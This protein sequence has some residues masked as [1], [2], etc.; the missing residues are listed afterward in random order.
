MIDRSHEWLFFRGRP[1][2]G[3][4]GWGSEARASMFLYRDSNYSSTY[5]SGTVNL[6]VGSPLYVGV[7]VEENDL[8]FVVVLEDCYIT[9]TSNP[10]DPVRYHFI[11]NKYVSRVVCE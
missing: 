2:G 10:N 5:P 11:E 3:I 7:F 6:P 4:I 9:Y 1:S 8:S